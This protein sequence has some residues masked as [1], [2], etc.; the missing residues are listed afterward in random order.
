MQKIPKF[1]IRAS[2][3]GTLLTNPKVKTELISQSVKSYAQEW[4]KEHIYGFK[5]DVKSKYLEKG[6]TQENN[7]IDKAIEWL[8]LPFSI[9]NDKFF[10]NEFFTGTPDLILEDLIIDIKCSWDC[11]TFPLFEKE[12]PTKDYYYQLQVY[13]EL[14]GIKKAKLVYILLN[15]IENDN[16]VNYDNLELKYRIK[17]FDVI[18]NPEVIEDLKNRVN[19]V[20]EY[21]KSITNE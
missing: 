12:I 15:N 13:M 4:L 10:E 3:S 11:F 21:I 17:T 14:T 9:K 8:D 19:N 1:K 20:R 7:A 16:E 2:A 5:K 18:Y 6:L